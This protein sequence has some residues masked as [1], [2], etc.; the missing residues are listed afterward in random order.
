[1]AVTY[2]YTLLCEMARPEIGG[3]FTIIGLFPN[4]IG[5]HQIPFPLP[6]LTFVNALRTDTPGAYKFR[7]TLTLLVTGEKLAQAEGLIQ[8]GAAGPLILPLTLQ[9]LQFKA[10]GSYVWSLEIIGQDEPFAFEFQIAHVPNP[11][12]PNVPHGRF[13]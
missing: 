2:D 8:T 4:G 11:L 10:F 1:M 3:K 7:A 12:G 6:F 5:T 13:N 9:N